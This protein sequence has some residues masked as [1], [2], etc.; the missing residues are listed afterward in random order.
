[1]DVVPTKPQ[2]QVAGRHRPVGIEL[3]TTSDGALM[4]LFETLRDPAQRSDRTNLA[5]GRPRKHRASGVRR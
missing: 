3:E 1:M 2:P 4:K 5:P